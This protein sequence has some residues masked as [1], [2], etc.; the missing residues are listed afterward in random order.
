MR[1]GGHVMSK[2]R[3]AL[4]VQKIAVGT[5]GE[6]GNEEWAKWGVRVCGGW[7]TVWWE[8]MIDPRFRFL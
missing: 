7:I 3:N 5:R 6:M 2:M 8:E 1:S 4:R